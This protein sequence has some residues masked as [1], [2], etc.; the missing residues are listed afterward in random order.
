M[1]SPTLWGIYFVAAILWAAINLWGTA[2]MWL[3]SE[4][5]HLRRGLGLAGSLS[6]WFWCF[7]LTA[8]LIIGAIYRP[9]EIP[10]MTAW[11]IFGLVVALIGVTLASSGMLEFRSLARISALDE[12]R[13]IT[14]GIYAYLRHPQHAGLLAIAFGLAIAFQT[15]VGLLVA[16]VFLF[17]SLIQ[18]RLEDQRLLL[19]FGDPARYYIAT[20]PRYIP[21]L[22]TRHPER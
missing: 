12:S 8:G 21:R 17:W 14:T 9:F 19:L 6:I 7:Y 15:L 13:L 4:Q 18:T 2:K 3:S 16:V 5:A 10:I 20:V 11:R 1:K 22:T